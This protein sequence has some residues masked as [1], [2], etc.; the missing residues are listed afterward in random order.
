MESYSLV[1]SSYDT[2][3]LVDGSNIK[4]Y[5]Y[6]VNWD[7]ILPIKNNINSNK[8]LVSFNFKSE[9]FNASQYSHNCISISADFGRANVFGQNNSQ[10]NIIGTIIPVLWTKVFAGTSY[11][12]FYKEAENTPIT[13]NRPTNNF[14][15][16]TL[17]NI[18][19]TDT[20]FTMQN[21]IIKFNFTPIK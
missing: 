20:N 13:I 12:S 18:D 1:L 11:H 16:I 6:F 3:N 21:Y 19:T 4:Q 9:F 2:V 5:K 8:Y 14:I 7:T 10:T 17:Q 15:T